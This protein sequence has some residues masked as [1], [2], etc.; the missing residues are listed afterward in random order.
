MALTRAKEKLYLIASIN[1]AEKTQQNWE[2]N[3]A[4]GDWL[5][6]DYVRA[7]CKKLS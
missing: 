3:A 6:K 1:D 7:E 5:L 2:S 4:H